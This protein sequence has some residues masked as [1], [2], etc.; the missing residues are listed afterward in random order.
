MKPFTEDDFKQLMR[1][2]SGLKI[3]AIEEGIT[4]FGVVNFRHDVDN[5]V[6]ASADFALMEEDYGIRSTYY[7]LDT[8]PYWRKPEATRC[9]M[10]IDN[11]MHY[12]GWHNNA[13]S[14]SFKTSRNIQECIESPLA[15][16]RRLAPV[17]G[18]AS[19]GDPLCYEHGYL[20]YYVFKGTKHHDRFPMKCGWF[21]LSDFGLKYEAYHTGHT[22]Y[23]SDSGGKWN[24]DNDKVIADFRKRLCREENVKLQIL[25]HPQWWRL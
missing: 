17:V 23:I 25:I 1:Q 13:L 16:L 10:E 2:L 11:R 24:Q 4:D 20:N 19:H 6:Q 9:I 12:I 15:E 18:T 14:V 22:H 21:Q 5:D 3:R 8:A 7:I